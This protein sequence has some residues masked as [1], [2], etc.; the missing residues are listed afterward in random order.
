MEISMSG[1]SWAS[2]D[3]CRHYTPDADYIAL[4]KHELQAKKPY[5]SFRP[6]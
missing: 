2:V 4:K 5:E 1:L 3:K 6:V